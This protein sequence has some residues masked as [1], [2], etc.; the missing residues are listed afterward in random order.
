MIIW[1][2][3]VVIAFSV[4]VVIRR[5]ASRDGVGRSTEMT[6]DVRALAKSYRMSVAA[7]VASTAL[8]VMSLWAP[9]PSLWAA[10]GGVLSSV[11]M[12]VQFRAERRWR[13]ARLGFWSGGLSVVCLA[14]AVLAVALPPS[15][16][17]GAMSATSVGRT[18]GSRTSAVTPHDRSD[19]P[20]PADRAV[21]R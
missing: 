13:L 2:L 18:P 19:T 10:A 5:A 4:F 14:L 8:F 11:S 6:F 7:L 20:I 9:A 17:N 1:A 3:P 15:G 16:E 12:V 21:V